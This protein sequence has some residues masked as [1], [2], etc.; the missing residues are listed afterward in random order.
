MTTTTA[1]TLIFLLLVGAASGI[2][3]NSLMGGL[4]FVDNLYSGSPN[5]RPSR[6]R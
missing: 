5:G 2:L 4:K 6:R 1:A 3:L